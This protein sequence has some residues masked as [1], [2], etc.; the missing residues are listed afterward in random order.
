VGTGFTSAEREE[1]VS[2]LTRLR[3]ATSPFADE[4]RTAGAHWA[5]PRLVTEI[6]Y[7]GWTE[8]LLLRQ[9]AFLGL[10][11]DKDPRTVGREDLP[12]AK[13]E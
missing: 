2:R 10:R 7:R 1:L 11:Q 6:E 3:R 13:E 9:A 5:Q 8:H 4:S 12:A